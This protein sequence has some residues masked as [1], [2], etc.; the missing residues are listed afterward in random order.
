MLLGAL[1]VGIHWIRSDGKEDFQ[2]R[3]TS[4]VNNSVVNDAFRVCTAFRQTGLTTECKVLTYQRSIDVSINTNELEARKMCTGIVEMVTGLSDQ[5]A[6]SR[7]AGAP[8]ELRISS[9]F[10]KDFHLATCDL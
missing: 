8:W 4:V 2:P 7:L 3:E 6:L 1:I 9:P 10:D 5:F